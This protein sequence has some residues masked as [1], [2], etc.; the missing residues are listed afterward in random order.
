MNNKAIVVLIALIALIAAAA[1]AI[2]ILNNGG[3]SSTH[4]KLT[5]EADLVTVSVDGVPGT[6]PIVM[7]IDEGKT[8]TLSGVPYVGRAFEGYYIDGKLVSSD[9]VYKYTMGKSDVVIRA[10]AVLAKYTIKVDGGNSMVSFNGSPLTKSF[11]G[12]FEY[13]TAVSAYAVADSGYMVTGWTGSWDYDG[14]VCS[15]F[16]DGDEEFS[17]LTKEASNPTHVVRVTETLEGG[18]ADNYGS[19]H[20]ADGAYSTVNSGS[21]YAITLE[22]GVMTPTIRAVPESGFVLDGWIVDGERTGPGE[23]A[24]GVTTGDRNVV[25]VFK[26]ATSIA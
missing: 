17:I 26:P 5:I 20:V 25:A 6:S 3:G 4:H 2:V 10:T 16:V 7:D 22:V 21:S 18:T 13:G 8:V 1:C 19:I 12:T 15:F 11:E 24:F 14:N 23:V 9:P